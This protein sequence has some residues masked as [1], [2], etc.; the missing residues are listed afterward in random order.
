MSK[1]E[2]K[3]E[4]N[5]RTI[6]EVLDNKKYTVDYFQRE[7]S[8]QQK[9]IEQLVTDLT[10]AFLIE[11][12]P[13]HS[14]DEVEN[15]NSYYLGPFVL[16]ERDGNRSII[17]GQQRLT[18]LTLFMIYLNNLQKSMGISEAIESMIFS[19]KVGKK[20]FNI[21]VK[22]RIPCLKSLFESGEYQSKP[23]DDESTHNMASRYEDIE[24]AFPKEID[25]IVLPYFIDWVKERVVLVEIV[26]YSD[27]NAY[28]IFETMNDRGLNLTP[29]EMLKG[30]VLSR[31]KDDGLRQKANDHWKSS[32][33]ALHALDKDDD[34]RFFQAW[35]RGKYAKTIRP[36]LAGS[37]NED[38]EKIGTRFHSWVR[39]N[40]SLMGLESATQDDF[41]VFVNEDFDFYRNAYLSIRNAE[42]T[43]LEPLEHV[44]YIHRWGIANSLSYPLLL[45][46]LIKSDDVD[47]V[48][49]KINLVARY[50]EA[51][52]VRRSVNFKK[53]SASSIRYTMYTLVKE[54]RNTDLSQL[55][56]ILASKLADMD[57]TW[58][59]LDTFRLHGQNRRFVKFL[60]SRISSFID[61]KSGKN[62]TFE[63]YYH[64]PNGK[65][66]EVEHIWADKFDR[67]KN[68]FDQKGDF[69]EYRNRVGA[70]VL[71]PRGSNQS[72]GAK[73]Y[74][75][76]LPHYIKENLLVQTL[77]ELTYQN[78]PNFLK[79][80]EDLKL[81]FESHDLFNKADI[82]QR[83]RLYREICEKIWS[84]E[85]P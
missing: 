55:Q 35:L 64:S 51:F 26:A 48:R 67:H 46:P 30:F 7:Y 41:S 5:D 40:L 75:E 33:Q 54:I 22:E 42:S 83:Q 17:D 76:K 79:M 78:N 72:Y 15:Y 37:K 43:F 14:R 80:K 24:S 12:Q 45:A 59:G 11:Y 28:T 16:S 32:I 52:V 57:Q 23:N 81:P 20:S 85:K 36:G 71:L 66:F 10:S 6:L 34:Q 63:S 50:I 47:T 68:E 74:K 77:C 3:I 69:E 25:A 21:I 8:W 18:S 56:L 44:Y 65:P 62:E 82:V 61:K 9:H 13:N 27:D 4:A 73:P 84:F 31:F 2:N 1:L 53:F 29:T 49:K 60:L 58:S 38:F 70:L 19:E 39:E